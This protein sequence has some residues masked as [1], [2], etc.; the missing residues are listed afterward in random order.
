MTNGDQIT[1]GGV[2]AKIVDT[3]HRRHGEPLYRLRYAAD[4]VKRLPAILGTQLWTLEEL[5]KAQKGVK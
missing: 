4:P 5:E 2:R 1:I 3:R